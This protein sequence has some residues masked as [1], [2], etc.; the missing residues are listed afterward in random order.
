M[1]RRAGKAVQI[2]EVD[3]TQSRPP[4]DFDARVERNKCR[5]P[6]PS[7]ERDT[8]LTRPEYRVSTVRT[9]QRCAP[10]SGHPFVALLKSGI[11]KVAAP[12]P[13]KHIATQAR[14]IAQL[15]RGALPQGSQ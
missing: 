7:I 14:H 12:R 8:M 2:S 10:R 5:R 9:V 13:L 11:A 15:L 4:Q 1:G 6:V 3:R